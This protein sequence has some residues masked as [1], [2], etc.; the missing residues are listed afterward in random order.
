MIW[1]QVTAGNLIVDYNFGD[2]IWVMQ[3]SIIKVQIQNAVEIQLVALVYAGN[4]INYQT[5]TTGA[6][7]IDVSDLARAMK[8]GGETELELSL[9]CNDD[10]LSISAVYKGLINPNEM[11]IPVGRVFTEYASILPPQRWI[12][13]IFGLSDSTE[14]FFRYLPEGGR[15][16]VEYTLNSL[17]QIINLVAGSQ[18]ISIPSGADSIILAVNNGL[19]TSSTTLSRQPI[20]CGRQYAAVEW[21]AKSGRVKRHTWEVLSVNNSTNT[22]TDFETFFGY[23][24]SKGIE[25]SLVLR[26]DGLSRYDYWYY[27]DIVT[28]SDVRVAV[29]ESD[30]DFGDETRVMVTTKNVSI[31]D[32]NGQYTLEVEIKYR[33][34]DEY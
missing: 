34:Y 14:V 10:S 18:D 19:V 27:S 29:L 1:T 32:A 28:S 7:S 22:Q 25:Q 15:A 26:L 5:D 30:A 13:P 12:E 8:A 6:L 16:Y 3:K 9:S 33:R 23:A 20:L 2:G 17:Q 24:V 21:I 4:N 11:L 31:P